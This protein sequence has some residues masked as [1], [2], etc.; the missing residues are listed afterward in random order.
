MLKITVCIRDVEL[1][2]SRNETN[3]LFPKSLD[4]TLFGEAQLRRAGEAAGMVKIAKGK[5]KAL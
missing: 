1:T 4:E 3:L 5:K 2:N